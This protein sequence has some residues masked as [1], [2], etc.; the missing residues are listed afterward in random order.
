MTGA[1][2]FLSLCM[3]VRDEEANLPRVLASVRGLADE[4][5]VTDTGSTDRTVE[6]ARAHGARVETFPWIDD[7]AA[8]RNHSLAKARGEWIL[9]LDADDEFEREDIPAALEILRGADAL[10][11]AVRQTVGVEGSEPVVKRQLAFFRNRPEHRYRFR[12]HENLTID[13][14]RIRLAP[15]RITH[16]GYTRELLPAKLERNRRLLEKMKLDDDPEARVAASYFLG[17]EAARAGRGEEAF[18]EFKKAAYSNVACAY[19]L[20]AVFLLAQLC[21]ESG[22]REYAEQ[23]YRVLL[24]SNPGALEPSL[25]L[26]ELLVQQGKRDEARV[27]L[28]AARAR[29][30]PLFPYEAEGWTERLASKLERDLRTAKSRP[31]MRIGAAIPVLN[32]WRFVPAVAGQLLRVAD[33]CVVLRGRRSFSGVPV[34]LSPVPPLDSRIE[35]LEGAWRN[36]NETR[37]AATEALADC[38]YL[39]IVDSDEIFLDADL[40]LLR[41]LCERESDPVIAVRLLTYWKTHE[42]RIDPPESLIAPVAYRRGV[43]TRGLRG[44]DGPVG[45]AR[46]WCRHLSYVRTDD[47]VREKLRLFSHAHEIRDGW[48]ENV[49]KAWD[50]NRALEN[51][52][53]THP[54]AYPRAV[55]DPDPRLNAVLDRWK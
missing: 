32:E 53:P 2:P 46:I 40:D 25:R 28:E 38:D 24:Q 37:N 52:H 33:R 27:H 44:V 3:I 47:E 15:L 7:F 30:A 8:A 9:V 54:T 4:I 16:R 36:E 18:A 39:F 43:R 19:R 50:S 31:R 22:Q 11:I 23:L 20:Y 35:V 17:R 42:Y 45:V 1:P 10:G 41:E 13:P 5:V 29:H 14:S 12:V 26:A 6:I 55:L 48:Y 49:W 51:L 34:A 21:A